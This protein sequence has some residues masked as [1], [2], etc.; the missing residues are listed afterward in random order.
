MRFTETDHSSGHLIE[1]YGADGIL[2]DGRQYRTSLILTPE[3]ILADW[4]PRAAADLARAHLDAVVALDPHVVV[5][6]TGTR[7][8]FPDPDVYFWILERGV[9]IEVMD[10]GAACR[11]YNILMSEGRRVAAALILD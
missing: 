8:V 1:G 5:L 3:R 11:T 4:Q 7:Q 10:T 2:V 9:G 6:G